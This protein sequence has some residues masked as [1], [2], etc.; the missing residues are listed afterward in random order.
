M[1]DHFFYVRYS[2]GQVDEHV[3][4]KSF[5]EKVHCSRL[6]RNVMETM[7]RAESMENISTASVE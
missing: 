1:E 4:K 5:D 2:E 3:P 6:K 7:R